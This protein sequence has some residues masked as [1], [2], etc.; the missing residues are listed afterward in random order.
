LRKAV[1]LLFL[2]S[3]VRSAFPIVYQF[4]QVREVCPVISPRIDYFV[5]PAGAFEAALEVVEYFLGYVD[6][7][8]PGFHLYPLR[9]G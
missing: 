5:R 9:G 2:L 7:K 6:F 8:M 4:F 3:P 1:Y